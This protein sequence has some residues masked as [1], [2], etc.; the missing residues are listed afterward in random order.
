MYLRDATTHHCSAA[1][2]GGA[3]YVGRLE[4]PAGGAEFDGAD[5]LREVQTRHRLA[6]VL[7]HRRHLDDH[8]R[9][10][11]APW[12]EKMLSIKMYFY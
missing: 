9:L 5:A 10:A 6:D 7:L 4:A 2:L 11:V 1:R 3:P 8:Q 12:R